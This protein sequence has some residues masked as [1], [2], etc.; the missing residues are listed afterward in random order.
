MPHAR[1]S[2]RDA[3]GSARVR[4]ALAPPADIHAEREQPV[5]RVVAG[6]DAVE[7]RLDD[8]RLVVEVGKSAAA[9]RTSVRS[10]AHVGQLSSRLAAAT[11]TAASSVSSPTDSRC[12]CATSSSTRRKWCATSVGDRG[13]QRAER[14]DEPLGLLVVGEVGRAQRRAH[15]AVEQ[16]DG[17]LRDLARRLVVLV[18]E[19]EQIG[20]REALLEQPQA[21]LH[22]RD[23][24]GR[25]A[26]LAVVD[27]GDEEV[28]ARDGFEQRDRHAGAFGELGEGEELLGG[29]GVGSEDGGGEGRVGGIEIAVEDAADQREGE[30]P[31][32]QL[33]DPRQALEVLGAVP[34]DPP[35]PLRRREQAALLV[36]AD[37]V[38]R[39]VGA[40]GQLLDPPLFRAARGPLGR[41]G[42]HAPI[43]GVFTPTVRSSPTSS[44]QQL[45]SERSAAPVCANKFA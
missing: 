6:R 23:V 10:P 18:R 15:V 25:V 28:L 8:P 31:A 39:E 37:R 12:S 42:R 19:G 14:F 13:E 29:L 44:H 26:R 27:P 9:V 43:L 5:Q 3:V 7:H 32:A 24:G 16:P 45:C 36:E 17:R 21:L 4:T 2:T 1:S 20:E 33:P 35:R 34:A 41:S 38:D 22:D 11:L 30:A 40:P